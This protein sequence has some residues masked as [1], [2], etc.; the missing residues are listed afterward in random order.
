[1]ETYISKIRELTNRPVLQNLLLKNKKK[2]N[3][4]CGSIDAIQSTQMAIDSY[5]SFSKDDN[6][7]TGLE[8]LIIYGLFQ[9]L[10]VQ[11]DSVFNL[12]KSM[13]IGMP[14]NAKE[15]EA[16]YPDLFEVRLLRNKGI[17]HPS[18]DI[19]KSTHSMMIEED[20]INLYSHSEIGDFSHTTHSI[21]SCIEKQ[22][23]V[24]CGISQQIIE[25]MESMEQEHKDKYMDA[26]LRD[27][28]PPD[29]QYH[30]GKLFEAINLIEA[31]GPENTAGQ[32]IGRNGSISLAISNAKT[33]LKAI[34]KFSKEF[35][36]RGL[37]DDYVNIEI[38]HSKYPLEKLKEYFSDTLRI[39]NSQDARA[40]ADS[41]EKHVKWLI[42]HVDGWDREYSGT[43]E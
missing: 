23:K 24:L 14:I 27:C 19:F 32:V 18:E 43:G 15:L 16:Q 36:K 39:F 11:Q 21:T 1:M 6:N 31:E 10:Y 2:W 26:K 9:A 22:N 29:P 5:E 13:S 35:G 28:F 7:K 25:K 34:D 8:F 40:Y 38:D 20:R 4:M 17:G 12:C 37:R 33:L 30:I 41:A 3:L 42:E